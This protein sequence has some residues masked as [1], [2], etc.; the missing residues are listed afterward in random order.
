MFAKGKKIL[1]ADDEP[2]I[3]EILQYNLNKEG[4]DVITAKDGEEALTKARNN[5]PDLIILDIMMPTIKG[6]KLAEAIRR[7]RSNV[8]IV[9]MSGYEPA[10]PAEKVP[11]ITNSRFL[12]KPFTVRQLQEI[13]ATVF[14]LPPSAVT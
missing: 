10:S 14:V 2:D 7:L 4:Y 6:R 5:K 3:L 11:P 1:I 9:L 13:V 8:P 12:Q